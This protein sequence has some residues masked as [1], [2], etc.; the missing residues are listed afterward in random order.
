MLES[1]IEDENELTRKLL[2]EKEELESKLDLESIQ[3][4]I[5]SISKEKTLEKL[6][7][8]DFEV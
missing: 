1:L 4:K 3:T 6:I 2:E 5:Q 8:E 7:A